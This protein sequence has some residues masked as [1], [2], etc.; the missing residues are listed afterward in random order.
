MP[1][2]TMTIADE[3]ISFVADVLEEDDTFSSAC[4][5]HGISRKTGYKWLERYRAEGID[6]LK[7]RSRAPRSNAN[8]ISAEVVTEIVRVPRKAPHLGTSK[9]VG[10]TRSYISCTFSSFR[11]IHL[12][13]LET[14]WS[15]SLAAV[16]CPFI[17]SCEKF[18]D[19]P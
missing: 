7:A 16:A 9:G 15:H 6:G 4:A 11:I 18:C 1:W 2:S 14:L 10:P 13:Y 3:K 12:Q 8:A 19:S 5:R 17:T